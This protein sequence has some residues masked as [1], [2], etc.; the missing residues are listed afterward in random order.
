MPI[1]VHSWG[2]AGGTI[3]STVGGGGKLFTCNVETK[4]YI[5]R[6][7]NILHSTSKQHFTFDVETTFYIQRRNKHFRGEKGYTKQHFTFNVET[8]F[9]IQ[10]RKYILHSTSKQ[11]F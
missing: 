8:T 5:Q 6:R 10:R 2:G 1:E 4:F 3:M 9:Y 7:N 11:T